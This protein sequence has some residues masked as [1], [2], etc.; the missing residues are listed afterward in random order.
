MKKIIISVL[1]VLTI[2]SFV[3]CSSNI[4]T[5]AVNAE[6]P[7]LQVVKVAASPVPHAEILTA[8][9]PL[10]KEKGYDLQVVEFTDYVQPNKVV[11][12]GEMEV[13][14]SISVDEENISTIKVPLTSI[15]GEH[16]SQVGVYV[17][18]QNPTEYDNNTGYTINDYVMIDNI[19]IYDMFADDLAISVN[20]PSSVQ[21]GSSA[22]ITATV[23][24][25]GDNDATSYTVS[26][27]AGDKVLL[28]ETVDEE[29]PSTATQVFTAELETS[30]YDEASTL[31]IVAEVTYNADADTENNKAETQIKITVSNL[32]A[33][34]NLVAEV[35]E[36]KGVD[37]SWD[38][39]AS[40][41]GQVTEDFEDTSIFPA[42]DLGG[43]TEENHNGAFGEWK[44]YD[45]TEGATV[46]GFQDAEF[47]NQRVPHAW[48]VIDNDVADLATPFSGKQFLLSVCPL[49][50][51]GASDHWLISPELTGN[52]QTISFML[53]TITASY[54]AETF[55][56]LAS[57]TDT[58][59]AS[60]VK[61]Q[62]FETDVTD[63]TE[64]TANLPA[65][66]KYFA[67]RH[68]SDD[69]F[70]LY[71]DDITFEKAA[72][73]PTAYNIYF[74]DNLVGT[75]EGDV[76]TFT[77][78]ADQTL[79]GEHNVGVTAV[80]DTQESAPAQAVVTIGGSFQLGDVNHDGQ[81]NITDVAL[82]VAYVLTK[83]TDNFFISEANMNGD[84]DVNI[85]DVTAL[86]ALVLTNQAAND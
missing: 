15:V 60:F 80:Y 69:I 83:A 41:A 48:Q 31:P 78:G 63:W 82:T 36:A 18:I 11:D 45:G 67:I 64:F 4:A 57:S 34:E 26:I 70:G 21:A 44:L 3:A 77:I 9:I 43:I 61:V 22:S 10:M 5:N 12:N 33:P 49:T 81:V 85:T 17:P 79:T 13:L 84:D 8:A 47:S 74:E 55:E 66:T 25:K 7:S 59:P 1:S 40:E 72:S 24:N 19:R 71:L 62:D 76:T 58:D 27:K 51:Y 20:A 56:V 35:N 75:V 28:N 53:R 73:K 50:R 30:I 39:P 6:E 2:L 54:G 37:L 29:L 65:G 38:A 14:G 86:V 46:Y 23:E 32:L 68:T 52:A 16:F 42:F